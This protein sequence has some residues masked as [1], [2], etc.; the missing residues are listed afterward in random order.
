MDELPNVGPLNQ[1]EM[2]VPINELPNVVPQQ[3]Q[4]DVLVNDD[5]DPN[6]NPN[7]NLLDVEVDDPPQQVANL[8][9]PL[10]VNDDADP[11]DNN[12]ENVID[13]EV[14]DP[15][16]QVADPLFVVAQEDDY[17]NLLMNH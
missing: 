3:D 13:V 8:P 2:P 4:N 1:M 6:P 11:D 12:D 9:P 14:D 15:P 16:Q 17:Q 7:P 5:A 10:L